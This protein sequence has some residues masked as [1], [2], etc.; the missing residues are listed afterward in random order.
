[1]SAIPAVGT[2][3]AVQISARGQ[4]WSPLALTLA[5]TNACLAAGSMVIND[6]FDAESDRI[7][8]PDRPI[9]SG[10][11]SRAHALWFAIALFAASFVGSLLVSP[12][13]GLYAGLVIVLSTAYS[14][15]LKRYL[16]VNNALVAAITC[17][18]L[19]SAG[20]LTQNLDWLVIPIAATFIFI[21]GREILKDAEDIE[22]DRQYGVVSVANKWGMSAAVYSGVI[23]LNLALVV[24]AGQYL[25][26]INDAWFLIVL[27]PALLADLVVAYRLVRDMSKRNLLRSLDA[28]AVA[29]LWGSLAFVVGLR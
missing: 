6:W 1:M 10:Q 16:F 29:L 15:I 20:L 11:I 7:N 22:G 8:K 4:A 25:R 28:S 26:R 24:A 17:Y 9:P 3:I 12:L 18:P 23:L 2:I 13:I 14:M 27:G 5:V 19:F 21:F